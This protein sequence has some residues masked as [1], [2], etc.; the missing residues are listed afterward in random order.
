[1]HAAWAQR[2]A[3]F[4][5]LRFSCTECVFSSPVKPE[6]PKTSVDTAPRNVVVELHDHLAFP[7]APQHRAALS[8]FRYHLSRRIVSDLPACAVGRKYKIEKYA[9]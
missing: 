3:S 2:F 5:S 8:R 1:M 4:W 7:A 9:H 6:M